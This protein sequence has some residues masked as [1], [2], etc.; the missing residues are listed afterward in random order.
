MIRAD[1]TTG[2]PVDM[3]GGVAKKE[4]TLQDLFLQKKN[5]GMLHIGE[6]EALTRRGQTHRVAKERS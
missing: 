2:K 5:E 1:D 3:I 4:I 6:E